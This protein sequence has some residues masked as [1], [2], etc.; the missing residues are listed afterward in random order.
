MSIT[1]LSAVLGLLGTIVGGAWAVDEHYAK[2]RDV[3]HLE[4][5]TAG[6]INTLQQRLDAK[7]VE[8]DIR[9]KYNQINEAKVRTGRNDCGALRPAC[10][11]WESEAEALK[12]K[13]K[14]TR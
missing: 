3:D 5:Q 2:V 8:D 12:M 10:L 9:T 11:Q 1:A 4:V 13:L 6:A 14:Q 7:I